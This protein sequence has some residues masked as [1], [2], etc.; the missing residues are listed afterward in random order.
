M[1]EELMK[2]L[3]E[4]NLDYA[5]LL[6]IPDATGLEL[7]NKDAGLGNITSQQQLSLRSW[8]DS[9]HIFQR[10]TKPIQIPVKIIQ[11]EE[12][13]EKQIPIN[14]SNMTQEEFK[15]ELSKGTIKIITQ[16]VP[17]YPKA[18]QTLRS[19]IATMNVT[20]GSVEGFRALLQHSTIQRTKQEQT[21]ED[22][23]PIKKKRRGNNNGNT[24]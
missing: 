11:D 24:N 7:I 3:V 15:K 19:K 10:F 9:L 21:L 22:L 12:G 17:R 4:N 13:N 5:E 20:S 2:K 23:T 18:F 16:E 6:L 8:F 1:S 14:I